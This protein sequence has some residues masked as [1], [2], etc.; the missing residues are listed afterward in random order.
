MVDVSVITV[1]LVICLLKHCKIKQCQGKFKH[2]SFYTNQKGFVDNSCSTYEIVLVHNVILSLFR[3][4][5]M[6]FV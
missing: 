1:T 2:N 6:E 5:Y 4:L 3:V